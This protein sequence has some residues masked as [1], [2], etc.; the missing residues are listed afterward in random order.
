MSSLEWAEFSR[1]DKNVAEHREV[2]ETIV[3]MRNNVSEKSKEGSIRNLQEFKKV[4]ST[5]IKDF[6]SVVI[7][8]CD[9]SET[10]GTGAASSILR[11]I[12]KI[13][14]EV[15]DKAIGHFS[16]SQKISDGIIDSSWKKKYVAK[17]GILYHEML[18]KPDLQRDLSFKSN[19]P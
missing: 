8:N 18:S 17:C 9:K 3:Q 10:S 11:H 6:N 2:L 12:W 16:K 15:I 14:F 19:E 5:L 1:K 7:E 13:S 4:S